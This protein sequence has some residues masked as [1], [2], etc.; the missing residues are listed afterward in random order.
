MASS[1]RKAAEPKPQARRAD[2]REKIAFFLG[3]GASKAFGYPLTGELLPNLRDYLDDGTLTK[4]DYSK[5]DQDLLRHGLRSLFPGIER[6]DRNKL[7]LITDILTLIDH[8]VHS[9]FSL[10]Q[11]WSPE[12]VDRF[13]MLL[14]QVI[15]DMVGPDGGWTKQQEENLNKVAAAVVKAT[16]NHRVG[17][18]TSNYDI[19]LELALF[20]HYGDD[21]VAETID[22]GMSWRD[23][24]ADESRIYSR[25]ANPALSFYKLHGSLNW[26]RCPLC[27]YIYINVKGV[28]VGWAAESKKS[29]FNTCHCLHWP[30]QSVLVTPSF[31]RDARDVNLTGIWR[32]ALDTLADA[33]RWVL[34]GYSLPPEDFAIRSML[35]KA[36]R[37]RTKA[38]PER[39]KLQI[40]IVQRDETARPQYEL[41]FPDAVAY[42]ASG[43]ETFDMNQVLN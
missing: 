8:A 43:L 16:K 19:E 34:I 29:D 25:P 39:G 18:I 10:V 23:P 26:L 41:L 15:A 28:I 40:W 33:D 35:I 9:G 7:P 24:G 5:K 30:L 32:N 20:E 38:T 1:R 27:E 3:A 36:Y 12:R 37:I 31:V 13:R 17:I 2:Q 22:F 4:W 14:E 11:G 6:L 21:K 42:H